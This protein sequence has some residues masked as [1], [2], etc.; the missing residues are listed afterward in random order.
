MAQTNTVL[1][2]I[3]VK[4]LSGKAQTN[5]NN[6]L[7][8]EPK[9]STV[10]TTA[11]TVFA[12]AL[13]N[14]PAQTLYLI[15]S[16][17]VGSPGTAM[18][19]EFEIRAFGDQYANDGQD[20]ET[21]VNTFHAYELILSTSF[22]NGISSGDF[23]TH[24]STP[25]T[26]GT[27][28]FDGGSSM[29][30]SRGRLQIIPEFVSDI[31]AGVGASNPYIPQLFSTAN[32]DSSPI[33]ATDGIDWYLDAFSGILFIQDP[34]AY[35]SIGSPNTNAAV[36]FKIK[37]FAYVGKY[38][39]Q[40][41]FTANDVG[42]HISA[43]EGGGFSLANDATASFESG[44][45]GITVTATPATNKITIG[46]ATDTVTF[47]DI[48]GSNLLITNTASITYFETTY[49]SSS[50]IY[51]S[52]STKFG[53]TN[54]DTHVFT[55]SVAILYTGSGPVGPEYGLQMSGSNFLIDYGNS[56][57]VTLGTHNVGFE[58]GSNFPLTG[59]GLIISQSFTNE[60]TTHN[61]VKI[62]ETELVD[63]SGSAASDSFLI[64]VKDRSLVISS[65]TLTAPIAQFGGL[66]GAHKTILYAQTAGQ[67]AIEISSDTLNLG[68]N[69]DQTSIFGSVI[70]VNSGDTRLRAEHLAP[71]AA[72][73]LIFSRGNPRSSTSVSSTDAQIQS[74]HLSSSLTYLGGALTA[75]AVSSSGLLFA[76]ASEGLGGSD[77]AVAMY[78]T[79]TGQFYHT[80]SS[81]LG[82]TTLLEASA[83]AGIFLSASE[84]TGFSIGLMQSASF[85]SGSGTGLTVTA[86]TTNNIEFELVGVL[87]SSQQIATEISGAIGAATASLSASIVGTANEVEVI[88]TLGGTIQIGLPDDVTI[89]GTLD[90]NGSTLATDETTFNLL[91]TDATTINFGGAAT[92]L[93]IGAG[94]GTTTIKNNAVVVGDLTVNG[95]TTSI[96]TE[97]LLVEDPFILL[98]SGSVGIKDGGIIVQ[99]GSSGNGTAL[100]FDANTKRWGLTGVNE[101]AYTATSATPKQYVVTI[102]SS[103]A[104]PT[105]APSDF[106]NSATSYLGMMYVATTDNDGD[107][108]TI[109]IYG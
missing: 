75:S 67:K 92:T 57:S 44:S 80:G 56:G 65:S 64:N 101:T 15:Q 76:S 63:I 104:N 39:D 106:G 47:A 3:A 8:Q 24:A 31:P 60:L 79:V 55:G 13:P 30:G 61:M 33:S 40:A 27:F 83:S 1:T 87:S 59:S 68:A 5:A 90:V 17:S 11:T 105:S 28:P 51:S 85:T 100:Y 22:D 84:G 21:T 4:R 98:N 38:Q 2:Q 42:L 66:P 103:A 16:E 94:T 41:T 34:V 18:F 7:G 25:T 52:G 74:T 54:D 23:N 86:G 89:A 53:D 50:I 14:N 108:N 35:G 58:I 32:P 102:S 82:D 29:T 93:D 81:A 43:S 10:Q 78:N 45:A 73:H 46:K 20:G 70:A 6:S 88:G 69:S 95:T 37:A 26:F 48:T 107:T 62:G 91:D 9:G 97:Q 36:P 12:E 96:N 99:S 19:A 49:E 109:W 77:I 71:L 72:S